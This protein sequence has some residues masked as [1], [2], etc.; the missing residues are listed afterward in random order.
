MARF[1][2]VRYGLSV[3]G[4]DL[5]DDYMETKTKGFGSEVRRRIMLG[6]YVLSAGYCDAFY[7]KAQKVRELIKNDFKKAFK[8]EVDVILSP[9]SPTPAF[10]IGEKSNDPLQMYLEDIFTAPNKLAGLPAISI[11]AGK[12]KEGLPIGIHLIAPWFR[13]DLLFNIGKQIED[14]TTKGSMA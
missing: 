3:E 13:E 12:S 8:D 1:D 7:N 2:G 14:A 4:K 6:T 9:T 5:I 11:P 10:K